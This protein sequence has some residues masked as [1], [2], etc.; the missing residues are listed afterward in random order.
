M[1][2][3]LHSVLHCNTALYFS[4]YVETEKSIFVR[5]VDQCIFTSKGEYI[6]FR[7]FRSNEDYK[8]R[9]PPGGY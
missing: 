5:I 2:T 1:Y 9:N 3:H 6:F 7:L 8:A 4:L